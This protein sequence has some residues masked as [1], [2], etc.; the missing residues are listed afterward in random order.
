MA[1][2]MP[3]H[4]RHFSVVVHIRETTRVECDLPAGQAERIR[5]LRFDHFELPLEILLRGRLRNPRTYA[6]QRI[7]RSLVRGKLFRL[8]DLFPCLGALFIFIGDRGQHEL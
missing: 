7:D 2:L 8:Q 4:N 1:D 6:I 3:D 5:L